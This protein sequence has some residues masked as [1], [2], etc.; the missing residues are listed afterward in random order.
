[1]V[2]I[3]LLEKFSEKTPCLRTLKLVSA[4][5]YRIFIFIAS[6]CPSKTVKNGFYFVKNA[7]FVLEIFKLL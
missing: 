4:I 2:D 6:D 1:M 3:F 5:I 7:C